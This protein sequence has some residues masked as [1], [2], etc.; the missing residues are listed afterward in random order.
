MG[1]PGGAGEIGNGDTVSVLLN[2]GANPPNTSGT[3]N[4]GAA[5]IRRSASGLSKTWSACGTTTWEF[6]N[7]S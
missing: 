4:G 7:A 2:Q 5:R 6:V 1:L 3:D